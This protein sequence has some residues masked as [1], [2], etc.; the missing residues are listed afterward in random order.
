[1]CN[2]HFYHYLLVGR[3]RADSILL[4]RYY[5]CSNCLLVLLWSNWNK[6]KWVTSR[7]FPHIYTDNMMVGFHTEIS[8]LEVKKK[9]FTVKAT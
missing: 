3:K 5:T 7:Q 4:Q 1:M 8:E 6:M 9:Y 2:N